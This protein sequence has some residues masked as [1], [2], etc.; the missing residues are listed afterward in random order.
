MV[1]QLV[2]QPAH[3]RSVTGPSPVLAKESESAKVGSVFLLM[4]YSYT[5]FNFSNAFQCF[6]SSKST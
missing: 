2:E 5:T 1:A 3:I 6:M 4:S